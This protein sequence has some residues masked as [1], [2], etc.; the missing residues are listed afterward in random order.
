MTYVVNIDH[1]S[2][3]CMIHLVGGCG[4]QSPPGTVLPQDH[5]RWSEGLQSL[6]RA[7]EFAARA[8]KRDTRICQTCELGMPPAR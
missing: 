1:A 5:G 3:V 8:G 4:N 2:S 6:D 7:R